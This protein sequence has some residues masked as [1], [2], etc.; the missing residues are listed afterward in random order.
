MREAL[1]DAS[2][3]KRKLAGDLITSTL[4]TVG[5][6]F[7]TTAPTAAQIKVYSDAMADMFCAYIAKIARD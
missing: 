2:A 1:P 7:S 4:S 3:A 6:R 5:K